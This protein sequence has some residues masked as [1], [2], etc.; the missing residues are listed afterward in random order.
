MNVIINKASLKDGLF[1][2]GDYDERIKD[3]TRNMK[4]DDSNPVHD[5]LK[6]VFDGLGEH[7]RKLC[8]QPVDFEGEDTYTCTGFSIGGS[9][10]SEG[11]TLIGF[12]EL[13]ESRTLNLVSPFLKWEDDNYNYQDTDELSELIEAG[14]HEV[15]AYLFEGKYAPKKQYSL[16]DEPPEEG[17]A[18]VILGNNA[19]ETV[20]IETKKRGRK[21]KTEEPAEEF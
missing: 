15:K 16:F 18:T 8:E 12:R 1:L 3:A 2:K 6:A 9:G 19:G 14:K 5:D 7:L 10:G 17:T 20:K 4:F 13:S 11:V 21:K